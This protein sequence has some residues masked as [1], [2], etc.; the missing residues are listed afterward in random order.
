MDG[1]AELL[2]DARLADPR[3]ATAEGRMAHWDEYQRLMFEGFA[4]QPA[5]LWFERAEAL[6]LTFALVQGI[7]D[8]LACPQLRA[9]DFLVEV[10]HAGRV[11]PCARRT[12]RA[13]AVAAST[14]VARTAWIVRPG[15]LHGMRRPA[16]R[17][18]AST[19]RGGRAS[20]C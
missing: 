11:S 7:D 4:K 9:R 13:S 14:S 3:F 6:H 17:G 20:N 2:G 12:S 1:V 5:K 15:V 10:Q 8:L 16:F 19:A 18:A